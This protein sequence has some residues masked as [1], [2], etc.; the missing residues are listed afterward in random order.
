MRQGAPSTGAG[1]VA[2][3]R[4]WAFA[5]PRAC[6]SSLGP[7]PKMPMRAG[8]T[9]VARRRRAATSAATAP[10]PSN[11]RAPPAT[12]RRDRRSARCPSR[13]RSRCPCRLPPRPKRSTRTSSASSRT[14]PRNER[15]RS[16][17]SSRSSRTALPAI[18]QR[19]ASL[20]ESSDHTAHEGRARLRPRQGAR[21]SRK[22][23][24]TARLSGDAR[25]P[26]EARIRRTWRDLV[27]VLGMSRMLRQIG[28]TPSARELIGIYARVSGISF[29]STRRSNSRN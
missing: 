27:S 7:S 11:G 1:R 23:R 2:P 8:T 25:G 19:L 15:R 26:R 14:T 29:A 18:H 9:V 10:R 28:T 13:R 21:R 17:R 12:A 5:P 4:V 24:P 3:R 6:A 22:E 16:R 20:A